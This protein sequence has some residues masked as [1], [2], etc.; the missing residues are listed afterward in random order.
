MAVVLGT[1]NGRGTYIIDGLIRI[2]RRDSARG[3]GSRMLVEVR[4]LR[5]EIGDLGDDREHR[6]W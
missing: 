5:L 4:G 6:R 3:G 1:H 2:E